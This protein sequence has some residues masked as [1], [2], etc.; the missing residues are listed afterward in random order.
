M[1]LFFQ[2]NGAVI[3]LVSMQKLYTA[4]SSFKSLSSFSS[5]DVEIGQ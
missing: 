4:Q 5:R 3:G 2:S 1:N